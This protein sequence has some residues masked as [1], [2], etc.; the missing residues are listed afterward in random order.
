M[1]TFTLVHVVLSLVGNRH[2]IRRCV[3]PNHSETARSPVCVVFCD[4]SSY[5]LDRIYVSVS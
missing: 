3:W 4:Y 2:W 5:Q 1:A